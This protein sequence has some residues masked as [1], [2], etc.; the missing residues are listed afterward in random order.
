MAGI[1][2]RHV[3]GALAGAAVTAPFAAAA[4]GQ[5]VAKRS[6]RPR[7]GARL[8]SAARLEHALLGSTYLGCGGGGSAA[9]A[10][11]LIAEDLAAG[12]AFEMIDVTQLEDDDRVACPYGLG[13]LA[14]TDQGAVIIAQPVE[15]AFRVLQDHLGERFAAVILGEIGPL[16]LAEGL[17]IAARLG[18]P[19]LDADTVGRATPEINQHSVRVAGHPLTPAAG[20]T[21]QGD[22]VV[23]RSVADPDRE[24]AVF[25]ALSAASGVIGVADAPITGKAAKSRGVLVRNSFT[26]AERIGAA[27]EAARREERDPVE[28]GRRAGGGFR[29]FE[30]FVAEADWQDEDGFLTGTVSLRGTGPNAGQD[31]ALSVK[32]EHLVARIGGRVAATCPDLITLIDA[33]TGEGIGNPEPAPGREVVLLGFPCAPI[34]RTPEGLAVFSPRYFGYDIDYEPIETRRL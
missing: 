14:E 11:A 28:A 27:V 6:S 32:N 16:S 29:L 9:E 23:L 24:E 20:V 25:R 31:A 5:R 21:M 26:L 15:E 2:R 17:S 13:S 19:A 3:V 8:L 33:K 18:V 10:R 4:R 22:E 12:R 1:P 30:G 7:P 34:W